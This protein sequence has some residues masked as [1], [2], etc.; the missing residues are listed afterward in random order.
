MHPPVDPAAAWAAV[1]AAVRVVEAAPRRARR[2]RRLFAAGAVVSGAIALGGVPVLGVVAGA[3]T[4]AL[5]ACWL[6]Q[7]RARSVRA[8]L[9]RVAEGIAGSSGELRAPPST[10]PTL[11]VVGSALN[12]VLE[13]AAEDRRRLREVAARAFRAQESERLRIASEL[14]EQTAQTLAGLLMQLRVARVTADPAVRERVL[15][16]LRGGLASVTDS[17]RRYARGLYPPALEDLGVVAAIEAYALAL[18]DPCAPVV[19]I[20][21]EDVEGILPRDGE[22]ALY[23][24]VQE[25]LS[26]AVRHASAT[27]IRVEIVRHG[28]G[29]RATVTDDGRG[30]DLHQRQAS[31]PCLGLLGLQ[32]RALYAG[33]STRVSSTPGEGTC[34][35]V[36]LPGVDRRAAHPPALA[37]IVPPTTTPARS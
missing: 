11:A 35:V 23:R 22:L 2:V 28:D 1:E 15:E 34:V 32:E 9:R 21:A 31:H 16:E 12:R 36:E 20:A 25:A 8:A 14:Q 29:V 17:V 30:F 13:G 37:P 6:E 19:S 7:R 3:L 33:G 24:V 10:D 27:S 4:G 5:G 26:N 18:A